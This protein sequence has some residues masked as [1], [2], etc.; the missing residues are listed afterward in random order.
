MYWETLLRRMSSQQRLTGFA[1]GMSV[2]R[3][4]YVASLNFLIYVAATAATAGFARITA[5]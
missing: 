4:I 3:C 5:G 2:M 1:S